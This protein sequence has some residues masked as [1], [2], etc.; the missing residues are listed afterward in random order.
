MF[1]NKY[2]QPGIKCGRVV[3]L[4]INPGRRNI[5]RLLLKHGAKIGLPQPIWRQHKCCMIPR[6]VYFRIIAGLKEV[7]EA[8][9]YS[10]T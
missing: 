6:E 10:S 2:A 7:V 9:T 3:Q 1:N 4:A 8:R 5:V